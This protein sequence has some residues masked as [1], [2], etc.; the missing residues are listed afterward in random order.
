LVKTGYLFILQGT[1][2]CDGQVYWF[3]TVKRTFFIDDPIIK[4]IIYYII[5]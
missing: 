5:V 1:A 2:H 3:N 4:K